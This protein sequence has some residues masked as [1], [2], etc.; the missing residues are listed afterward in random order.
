MANER[1][2]ELASL[3]FDG[4]RFEGTP[5]MWNPRRTHRV[6]LADPRVCEGAVAA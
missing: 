5:S 2:I 3:R 1:P 4:K 6:S